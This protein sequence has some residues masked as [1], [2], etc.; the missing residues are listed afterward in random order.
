MSSR[1]RL[2]ALIIAGVAAIVV[3]A[4][5]LTVTLNRPKVASRP[6]PVAAT[7]P[8]ALKADGLPKDF[9]IG[10]VLT[11]GRSGEPGS[12]YNRAAQGAI[13]AAQRF[14][15]GGSTPTLSAQNDRGTEDGASAAVRALAEQGVSGVIVTSTG[16]QALAAAK[17]A[18]E[19]G[20]PAIL[21][22]VE[23]SDPAPT[24]WTTRPSGASVETALQTALTGKNRVLLVED[25]GQIPASVAISQTLSLGGFGEVTALAQEAAIRTGDQLRPAAE[26]APAGAESTRIAEPA[27]AVVVSAATPQRLAR[28]VQALQSRDVSVPLILPEGATTP[29]F[30]SSLAELDGTASG[31]LVSVVPAGGDATALQKDAQGRGMSAFLSAVRLV[32]GDPAIKNLS[33][34]APFSADAWAADARSHDAVVALVRAGAAAGSGDP[35]KVGAALRTLSFGPGDGLAGPELDFSRAAALSAET[36][37]VYASPQD[38]GLRPPDEAAPRLVWVPAP[39]SP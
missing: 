30:A 5:V 4:I 31:Q 15:R 32:S 20:L 6:D 17:T 34:D 22:Y 7:V 38:L 8:V 24:T 3:V 11:L 16:P 33:D 14:A 9:S 27:D 2:I 19:L 23:P 10:V 29:A 25:G 1:S 35:S 39:A 12:E 13:V 36:I 21:P 18:E 26:D 37:P 28:L